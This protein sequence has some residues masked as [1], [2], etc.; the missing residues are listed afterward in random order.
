MA[1]GMG[2]PLLW[3][4]WLSMDTQLEA[5][6]R[7]RKWKDELKLEKDVRLFTHFLALGLS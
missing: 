5:E 7:I 3:A 6:A 2:W 1:A 4:F